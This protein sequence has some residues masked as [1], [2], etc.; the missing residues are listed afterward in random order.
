MTYYKYYIQCY[1]E[2]TNYTL[3]KYM[4]TTYYIGLNPGRGRAEG[5]LR[6]LKTTIRR[7]HRLPVYSRLDTY[8]YIDT[9][10]SLR[11]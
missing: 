2:T 5:R 1:F 11:G 7:R 6:G 10:P 8:I 4:H 3:S 9:Y